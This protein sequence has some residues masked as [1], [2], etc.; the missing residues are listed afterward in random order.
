MF[1]PDRPAEPARPVLP[2]ERT[3]IVRPSDTTVA[4]P[5]RPGLR[6]LAAFLVVLA[7]VAAAFGVGRWMAGDSGPA[8]TPNPSEAVSL[9]TAATTTIA[10]PTATVPAATAGIAEPVAAA[11]AAVAPAVVQIDTNLGTGSGVIYSSEG[12]ILTAAHVV[13]TARSVTVRLA[14]GSTVA[15]TVLGADD[16]TDVAVV[17]ID[18]ATLPGIA[19]LAVGADLQVGQI[20]VAVGS[21]FGLDQT[22]TAGIVSAVDRIVND[23]SMVQTDAA[24]NPGNSGGPLVDAQGRVIGINDVIF[25][26]GG[27][28]EGVGF[29]ISIDLAKIVAD[30]IVAGE[31]VQ[32]A[33]LGVSAGSTGDGTSGAL[34]QEVVPGTAADAAGLQ[35]GDRITAIDGTP[36]RDSSELRAQIITRAPG[37]T[38]VLTIQRNGAELTVPVTLGATGD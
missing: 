14:D 38:A 24:I 21:P 13:G 37:T 6:R 15:G 19:E 22:V 18:V 20:A 4:T 29:A 12:S 27:G 34:L 5:P 26:N 35:I 36:I 16:T 33:Y 17:D 8:T 23:I 1:T 30:D 25:S 10:A 9:T 7:L 11:A 3:A 31:R 32:L 2:G 28:N